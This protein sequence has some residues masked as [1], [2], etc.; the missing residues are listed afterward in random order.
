MWASVLVLV[1]RLAAVY[2]L[3]YLLCVQVPEGRTKY[4]HNSPGGYNKNERRSRMF[5]CVWSQHLVWQFDLRLQSSVGV[6]LYFAF[7]PLIKGNL[8]LVRSEMLLSL[9]II[10]IKQYIKQLLR[11]F[12]WWTDRDQHCQPLFWH[13]RKTYESNKWINIKHLFTKQTESYQPR[14]SV[15]PP[16]GG[17]VVEGQKPQEG[18]A[19]LRC[20]CHQQSDSCLHP[21]GTLNQQEPGLKQ[22]VMPP[23][24]RED[25]RATHQRDFFM[26]LWWKFVDI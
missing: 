7:Q 18:F 6:L 10:N 1:A 12:E 16:V 20:W 4:S 15:V 2:M 23:A 19:V 21:V 22:S 9:A 17:V 13:G 5:I 14:C 8:H 25:R 26:L 24:G 3:V 11:Y